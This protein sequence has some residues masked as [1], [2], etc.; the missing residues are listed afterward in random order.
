MDD[1]SKHNRSHHHELTQYFYPPSRFND[2][3]NDPQ[4]FGYHYPQDYRPYQSS[5][6]GNLSSPLIGGAA[7]MLFDHHN[8]WRGAVIGS[9]IGSAIGA[10]IQG[11]SRGGFG[12]G[13]G[14][15]VY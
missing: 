10:V 2:S 14:N 1:V 12:T 11:V 6:F 9:A 5:S 4:H 8:R 3:A 7:G 15:G 13:Y